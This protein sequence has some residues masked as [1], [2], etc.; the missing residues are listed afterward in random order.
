VRC[1]FKNATNRLGKPTT[2]GPITVETA[3][4]VSSDAFFY[5]LGEDF[6]SLGKL[7]DTFPLKEDLERFGF[8]SDSGIELPFEWSGRIPDDTVKADLVR[9]GVL[10]KNEVP[11]LQVG[12]NVQ[13]A[14]G[15]GLM[16]AT[17][18]Q[19][20]NAYATIANG[21]FLMKTQIVKAI[22]APLT[23]DL[24]PGVADLTAGTIVEN[25]DKPVIRDILE[26]PESTIREPIVRGLQRVVTVE[27]GNY[28][29][30]GSYHA[31]TGERLF[32]DY[33]SSAIPIAGKTGTVQG[34][35]NY[36]WNDSSA[37][38][39]FSL[40]PARPYTVMAF[41]EKSGY[42]SKAAAPVVKCMFLALSDPSRMDP[43]V[44]SDPLDLNATVPAPPKE[45]VNAACL[46]SAGGD[47]G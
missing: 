22:Y 44:T 26:M 45:L 15:Q 35:K 5:K 46:D 12:D 13:V 34:A 32:R 47:R 29:P 42:G 4:A 8:G 7:D 31:A 37:F 3:L 18:L 41:L 6:F 38:G 43:V 24:S 36:P 14:I 39:G 1:V 30:P 40:D 16:A 27:G 2:Y 23:P 19:I 33:P 11:R 20:A 21:G 10:G 25:R 28:W 17:P 9:R